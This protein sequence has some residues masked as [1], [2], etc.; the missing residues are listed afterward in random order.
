MCQL[1][2]VHYL[3]CGLEQEMKD[4]HHKLQVPG[5]NIDKWQVFFPAGF[6]FL[7]I[8]LNIWEVLGFI[9]LCCGYI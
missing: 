4:K 8:L 7:Y 9:F 2:D 3:S 5:K 1:L 6:S